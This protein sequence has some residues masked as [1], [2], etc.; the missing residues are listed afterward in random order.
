MVA[1][2]LALV[3]PFPSGP[4]CQDSAVHRS[5]ATIRD[6]ARAARLSV[7][8]VSRALNDRG[9]VHP[10]TRRRVFEAAQQLGYTPNAAARS[11][12]TARSQAIGVV[13]P[14]LHG[15]FFGELVRGLD[16]AASERGYFL[17]L[18]TM[19]ADPIL[20]GKAMAAMRGRVDGLI[21]MAPEL[22]ARDL[23]VALPADLPAVLVDSPHEAGRHAFRVDN[24]G[25][26]ELVVRLMLEF[27]RRRIVHL[28]GRPANIDGAER[29][30]GYAE[31]MA[32]LAPDLPARVLEG[33][34]SEASGERLVAGLLAEGADFDA[35]F[36]ANDMMA[37][38]ALQALREAG[39]SMPEAVAVAGFD[40][41]PLARHLGLTT[42]RIDMEGIGR[43]AV[44][45]LTDELA[46]A[47]GPPDLERLTPHLVVRNSTSHVR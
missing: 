12:S 38:G 5:P 1:I 37:L 29:R 9:A 11:L 10:D 16:R 47:A 30:A 22:S 15:E 3:Y 14:D 8:S 17:L 24:A 40:D 45:R 34:F 35:V 43:R 4:G 2:A 36:A 25:G 18:S 33:D 32:R 31:A 46:G 26:A 21:V 6:V 19:H 42:V 41:I 28:A 44:E 27:G 39:V 23:E 13:L 7:A 20:A